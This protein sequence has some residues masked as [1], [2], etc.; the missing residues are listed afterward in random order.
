MAKLEVM[1]VYNLTDSQRNDIITGKLDCNICPDTVFNY[2]KG[3]LLVDNRFTLETYA[4]YLIMGKQK[5]E[6]QYITSNGNWVVN[7]KRDPN[8][9][10]WTVSECVDVLKGELKHTSPEIDYTNALDSIASQLRIDIRKW[11]QRDI[12]KFVSTYVDN[13]NYH[14]PELTERGNLVMSSKYA[15]VEPMGWS[16]SEQLDGIEGKLKPVR[17]HGSEIV[18]EL[19]RKSYKLPIAWSTED[20]FN[21]IEG[22]VKPPLTTDG[23]WVN[24][25]TREYIPINQLTLVEIKA[26]FRREVKPTFSDKKLAFEIKRRLNIPNTPDNLIKQQVITMEQR[27][28]AQFEYVTT[29]LDSFTH[30]IKESKG[31]YASIAVNAQYTMNNLL[32]QIIRLDFNDFGVAYGMV[33]D[34]VAKNLNTVFSDAVVFSGVQEMDI[35]SK[36]YNFYELFM[37]LI[38]K[39]ANPKTRFAKAKNT[40]LNIVVENSPVSGLVDKLR[41]FYNLN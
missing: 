30:S 5:W 10:Q 12:D 23:L 20:I 16:K 15:L 41:V 27:D 6:Q 39:T 26:M 4:Q 9:S 36:Q 32:N 35:G 22:N 31:K 3:M 11:H 37:G 21:Y 38:I 25:I 40:D 7:A 28:I 17:H 34:Y 1:S 33:L 18:T 29:A 19:L 13:H 2:L 14:K 8:I 24:D